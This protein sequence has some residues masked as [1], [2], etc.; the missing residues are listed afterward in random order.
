MQRALEDTR[1]TA[2]QERRRLVQ[3]TY[4]QLKE[5]KERVEGETSGQLREMTQLISLRESQ[6]ARLAFA[7]EGPFAPQLALASGN[8]LRSPTATSPSTDAPPSR[9]PSR[10]HSASVKPRPQSPQNT[11]K[12]SGLT[13]RSPPHV[14]GFHMGKTSG[15]HAHESHANGPHACGFHGCSSS[16]QPRHSLDV[17]PVD[18][19]GD[20]SIIVTPTYSRSG[21]NSGVRLSGSGSGGCMAAA[22]ASSSPMGGGWG[23]AVVQNQKRLSGTD[24]RRGSPPVGRPS[25]AS[26]S[27]TAR[28]P[29][30]SPRPGS[31]TAATNL[32]TSPACSP[33]ILR[34]HA[35][36]SPRGLKLFSVPA[37]PPSLACPLACETALAWGA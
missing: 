2:Q 35:A 31:A 17:A 33:R 10:S 32:L 24:S 13:H 7:P 15:P 18:R 3:S 28:G 6:L 20:V 29:M 23:L 30:R 21:S 37:T 25:S 27:S 22:S 4:S 1:V 14:A 26:G 19:D 5:L 36:C 12:P 11:P 9:P 34:T 16:P 8:A